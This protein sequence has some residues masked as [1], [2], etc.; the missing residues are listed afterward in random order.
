[1]RKISFILLALFA[2]CG[3]SPE[4][5]ETSAEG[6]V[7][8]S[9]DTLVVPSTSTIASKLVCGTVGVG[10]PLPASNLNRAE[11]RSSQYRAQQA[12]LHTDIARQQAQAEIIQAYNNYRSAVS[13]LANYDA[14]IMQNARQ[15]LDGKRYAYHRGETSLL[16]HYY[17]PNIPTEERNC[18]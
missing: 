16:G 13:R 5:A 11:V 17:N 10:I 9:G 2:G 3:Q 18:S 6:V 4:N 15:M 8:V 1:M 12:H 7:E 14:P